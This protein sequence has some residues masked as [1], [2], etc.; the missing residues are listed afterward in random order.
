MVFYA[1]TNIYFR[2]INKAAP[3]RYKG[4]FLHRFAVTVGITT[5]VKDESRRA[6]DLRTTADQDTSNSL[7]LG[8][9]FRVTPSLRVGGGVL[10]FKETDPNPLIDQT[11]VTMTPYV[12]FTADVDVAQL[13]RSLF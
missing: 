6:E 1:G 13:F 4:S 9:G 3:L 12:A 7:L 8:A 2:P 11:S 10:V 5:T